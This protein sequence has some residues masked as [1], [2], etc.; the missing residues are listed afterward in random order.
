MRQRDRVE[1]LLAGALA[2]GGTATCGTRCDAPGYFRTPTIV[3]GLGDDVP[4]VA[5][6]QFGPVLPVFSIRSP[7]EGIAG[8]NA[9]SFGLGGSVWTADQPRGSRWL[10]NST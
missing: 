6:E 5:E 9:P 2:T 7:E 4:L 1:A 10:A 8:A 3:T